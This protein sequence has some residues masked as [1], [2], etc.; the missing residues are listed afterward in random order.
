[1]LNLIAPH[2]L[3]GRLVASLAYGIGLPVVIYAV[4]LLRTHG[5]E[6]QGMCNRV[7]GQ[8]GTL[9]IQMGRGDGDFTCGLNWDYTFWNLA[10]PALG[11]AALAFI[12]MGMARRRV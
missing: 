4:L 11:F 5:N 8:G 3:A 1:M 12:L 2:S 6:P 9:P 10:L 7:P